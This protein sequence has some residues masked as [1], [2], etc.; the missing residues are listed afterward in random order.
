MKYL[1]VFRFIASIGFL[2][3]TVLLTLL[4]CRSLTWIH[5]TT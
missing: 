2:V 1:L 4:A 5:E 3:M